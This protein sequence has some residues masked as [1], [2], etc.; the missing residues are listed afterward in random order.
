MLFYLKYLNTFIWYHYMPFVYNCVYYFKKYFLKHIFRKCSINITGWVFAFLLCSFYPVNELVVWCK[1]KPQN[2]TTQLELIYYWQNETISFSLSHFK[3]LRLS[4]RFSEQTLNQQELGCI[5]YRQHPAV[6]ESPQAQ[7][8]W[9]PKKIPV[10]I[11]FSLH[12]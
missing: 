8:W 6:G 10:R 2:I 4:C 5:S 12:K 1:R 11:R 9:H 3:I 7:Q